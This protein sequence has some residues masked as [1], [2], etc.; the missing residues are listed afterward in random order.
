[1]IAEGEG[2]TSERA[3]IGEVVYNKDSVHINKNA[4][5]EAGID[6]NMNDRYQFMR[7]GYYALDSVDSKPEALVFNE[8]VGLKGSYKPETK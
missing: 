7:N 5:V 2:S 1:M 6:Y 8:V 4:Y 3:E